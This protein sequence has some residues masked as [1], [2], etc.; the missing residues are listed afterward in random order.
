M[1]CLEK[2]S[3]LIQKKVAYHS[4]KPF[5]IN[6]NEIYISHLCFANDILLFAE[7]SKEQIEN[8]TGCLNIF[9]EASG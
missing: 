9:Y 5:I 7:A 3:Q 2:L 6:R 1:L 4:C 8:I